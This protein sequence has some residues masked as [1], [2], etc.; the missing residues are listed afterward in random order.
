MK[1]RIVQGGIPYADFKSQPGRVKTQVLDE[2]TVM[3]YPDWYANNILQMGVAEPVESDTPSVPTVAQQPAE[4]E[5]ADVEGDEGG[6]DEYDITPDAATLAAKHDLDLRVIGTGSG[7]GGR[8]LKKD[9]EAVIDA[10]STE[11]EDEG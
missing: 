2:G 6:D 11:E 8:I 5:P 7:I 1:V 10:L 4:P 9:V 3:D